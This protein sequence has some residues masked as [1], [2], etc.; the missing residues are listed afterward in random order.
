MSHAIAPFDV[1]VVGGGG[2]AGECGFTGGG[3]GGVD[4]AHVAVASGA[5]QAVVGAGGTRGS[6]GG[7]GGAGGTSSFVGRV[8]TGGGGG[9]GFWGSAG[10]GDVAGG[11][12]NGA[13]YSQTGTPSAITG[14]LVSYANGYGYNSPGSAGN[15]GCEPNQTA[16]RA[17]TVIVR[18][19]I[20]P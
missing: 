19:E 10:G 17:G 5:H 8:A 9:I 6:G 16:G 7:N 18:Y 1:L 20:A 12:P 13:R 4:G 3:G 11:T 14:L 2:G 15:A